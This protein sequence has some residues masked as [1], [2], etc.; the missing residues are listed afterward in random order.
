M[1]N[2]KTTSSKP[3]KLGIIRKFIEYS[4]KTCTVYLYRFGDI[5]V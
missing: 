5:V 3:N 1:N 4:F 2:L